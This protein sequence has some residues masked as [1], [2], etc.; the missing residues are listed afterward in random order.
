MLHFLSVLTYTLSTRAYYP[1][2]VLSVW[3]PRAG[4]IYIYI[5]IHMICV[6]CVRLCV[7]EHARQCACVCSN[8]YDTCAW[9]PNKIWDVH[10]KALAAGHLR[11]SAIGTLATSNPGI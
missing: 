5:Y 10:L 3:G 8:I 4:I 9:T 2:Y 1:Y 7:S 11:Y 6:W